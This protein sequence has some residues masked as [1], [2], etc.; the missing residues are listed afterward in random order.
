ML[1]IGKITF[2]RFK[3]R[4]MDRPKERKIFVFKTK[5]LRSPWESNGLSPYMVDGAD[6]HRV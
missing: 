5:V 3:D 2:V 6:A 1:L 4:K